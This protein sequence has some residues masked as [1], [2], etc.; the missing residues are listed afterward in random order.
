MSRRLALVVGN[1]TYTDPRFNALSTPAQDVHRLVEL[2]TNPRIGAFDEVEPLINQTETVVS[3]AV[4]RFFTGK[5]RDD[6]LLLYFSGHGM[7]D[8]EGQLYLALTD[9]EWD[10]PRSSAVAAE[11]VARA[12]DATRSNRVVLILDCCHSGAFA[13]GAKAAVGACVGTKT[14]FEGSGYGRCVLTATDATQYAW[15]GDKLIGGDKQKNSGTSVFTRYLVEGLQNGEADADQDGLVTVRELS[16]YI[17]ERVKQQKLNQTPSLWTYKEQGNVVVATNPRPALPAELEDAIRNPYPEVRKGAVKALAQLAAGRH[18]GV[19]LLAKQALQRLEMDDSRQVAQLA[20]AMVQTIESGGDVLAAL[21][22]ARHLIEKS[23]PEGTEEKE[24]EHQ[25]QTQQNRTAPVDTREW[26]ARAERMVRNGTA[27]AGRYCLDSVRRFQAVFAQS[28]ETVRSR[29]RFVKA[30]GVSAAVLLV[31]TV[32]YIASGPHNRGTET[33]SPGT[34]IQA[35]VGQANQTAVQNATPPTPKDAGPV[36]ES[37]APAGEASDHASTAPAEIPQPVV[38]PIRVSQES[39]APP[40]RKTVPTYPALARTARVQGTV[41]L[42]AII[43]ADGRV[44]Q[45]TAKKGHPML[46]PP[47]IEAV[48]KWRYKPY[49]VDGKATPVETEIA[50][51][52][53]LTNPPPAMASATTGSSV[54]TVEPSAKPAPSLNPILSPDKQVS[55][56]RALYGPRPDYTEQ[57]RQARLQ[58]SVVLAAV[59][60]NDGRVGDVRVLQSLGMGLDEKAIAAVRQWKFAAATKD[61][62]PVAVT[63]KIT[64]NFHLE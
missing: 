9:T 35:K 36:N 24:P 6:L 28:T 39:L 57:A 22:S 53:R 50:V 55:P 47:A 37:N 4:E 30:V 15:E 32:I 19:G 17:Y 56:P 51:R 2:L 33:Q 23:K 5:T 7:L 13:R 38:A 26:R 34:A 25:Q 31:A 16:S 45:V 20:T 41:V 64:L 10:A 18:T 59:I 43:D 42:A 14:A 27:L 49:L 58:G 29:P 48:R 12:M 3:R 52:F 62:K 44:S 1:T 60:E 21:I 63:T 40:L 54:K 11:F 61:G 46:I 8:E